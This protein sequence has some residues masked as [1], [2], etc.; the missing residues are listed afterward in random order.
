MTSPIRFEAIFCSR[1]PSTAFQS[2]VGIVIQREEE[3]LSAGIDTAHRTA[4]Y[5]DTYVLS[6]SGYPD[7]M[8][9]E[10][11]KTNEPAMVQR[12]TRQQLGGLGKARRQ[13][14]ASLTQATHENC[15][16]LS[17]RHN[18]RLGVRWRGHSSKKLSPHHLS[19]CLPCRLRPRHRHRR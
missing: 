18:T 9:Q 13:A 5:A 7:A 1:I 17:C 8:R 3:H 10:L 12:S 15:K 19:P 6:N 14:I 2:I 4:E 11:R 16:L